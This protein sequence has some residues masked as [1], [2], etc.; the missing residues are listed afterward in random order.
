MANFPSRSAAVVAVINIRCSWSALALSSAIFSA[1]YLRSQ[2]STVGNG[3]SV[4]L[5]AETRLRP[6]RIA[7]VSVSILSVGMG[8]NLVGWASFGIF[9]VILTGSVFIYRGT[10]GVNPRITR[11]QPIRTVA[12][13]K[14]QSGQSPTSRWVHL[15]ALRADTVSHTEAGQHVGF[16]EILVKIQVAL[17]RAVIRNWTA[18]TGSDQSEPINSKRSILPVVIFRLS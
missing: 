9:Y 12:G 15:P 16:R 11:W 14:S 1:G 10:K 7:S 18:I 13:F 8:G 4:N 2:P 5:H 17:S 3:I 6:S